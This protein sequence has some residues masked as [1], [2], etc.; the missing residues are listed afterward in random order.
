ME[1]RAFKY[2]G[3]RND[4]MLLYEQVFGGVFERTE[5]KCRAILMTHCRKVKDD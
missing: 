4:R 1:S 3:K 2:D 5:S